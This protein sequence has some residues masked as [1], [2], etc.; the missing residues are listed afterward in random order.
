MLVFTRKRDEAIIIGNGIEIRVVR[1]GKDGVR[2]GITAPPDV[3]VHRSEIYR[4]VE[5]SNASAA[6][7]TPT[8]VTRVSALAARLRE[9]AEHEPAKAP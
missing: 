2:I 3:P 7:G 5:S 8:D 9:A 6:T 4:L 1:I